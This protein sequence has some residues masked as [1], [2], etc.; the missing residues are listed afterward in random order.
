MD[1]VV[2]TVKNIQVTRF[3]KNQSR[4]Q[5]VKSKE[6]PKSAICLNERTFIHENEDKYGLE[7]ELQFYLQILTD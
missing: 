2:K 5:R 1:F 6:K 3:Q 7:S 4:F